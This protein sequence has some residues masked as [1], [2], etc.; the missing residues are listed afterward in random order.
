MWEFCISVDGS[1]REILNF[2]LQKLEGEIKDCNGVLTYLNK[3]Q[4]VDVLIAC[5][6]FE[7]NRILMLIQEIISEVICYYY[8]KD[9][10][11]RN[12]QVNIVDDISKKAFICALLYFDNETDIYIVNKYLE[13]SKKMN[14]ESFFNF[15]LISLKQKWQELVE[16][17]NQNEIYLYKDDTFL[18]LIKFLVDNIE[19]KNDVVNI[20]PLDTSYGIFDS[21]FDIIEPSKNMDE[22][23]LVTDLIALSPKSINIYCSEILSNKIKTLICKLFEKRVKFMHNSAN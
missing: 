21:K 3:G 12:L 22:E 1:K 23:K 15:R 8:K 13:L 7:K 19:V 11:I 20:M 4:S 10:L 5:N 6:K 9:F 2:I 14:I 16:I 17:A 18:E